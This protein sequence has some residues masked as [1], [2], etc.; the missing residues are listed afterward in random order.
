MEDEGKVRQA[1]KEGR[2]QHGEGV[3]RGLREGTRKQVLAENPPTL[4]RKDLQQ[5]EHE[6]DEKIRG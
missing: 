4:E 6:G 5:Q 1:Y 2:A 3:K